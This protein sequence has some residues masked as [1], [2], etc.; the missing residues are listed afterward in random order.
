LETDGR[1]DYITLSGSG[2][3]SLHSR[4]GEV[5][6]FIRK[7]STIPGVLLTNGTLLSLPEVQDAASHAGVV[8]TSLSAWD[9]SSYSWMNR[10]YAELRFDDMVEGQK[11]FRARFKGKLWLEVFLVNGMNTRVAD[12]KKIASL[13]TEISPDRIHLNTA[14]RPPAEDFVTAL[15]EERMEHLTR[16]FQPPGE[17]IGEY[18]TGSTVEI[19]AN[20]DMIL[21]MLQRRPCSAW[22]IAE[23]YGMHLNDVSKYLGKL[24]RSGQIK[25]VPRNATLYY[26]VL[27]GQ[28]E[29]NAQ[30]QKSG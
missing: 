30:K 14:T 8:K 5:L 2:E 7:N 10:P 26:G 20:Q 9:E 17:I 19:R 27:E 15:P 22:Q 3:P 4:F 28:G 16:L 6:E 23:T 21:S 24:L 11:E 1:A 25:A 29:R 13:A 18:H 12:V